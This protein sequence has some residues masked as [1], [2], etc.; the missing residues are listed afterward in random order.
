LKT[1]AHLS[2]LL[3]ATNGVDPARKSS[4]EESDVGEISGCPGALRWRMAFAATAV[5]R[6]NIRLMKRSQIVYDRNF[7]RSAIQFLRTPPAHKV[8]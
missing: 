6:A 2:Y 4:I 3:D 1:C 8:T 5:K 7:K